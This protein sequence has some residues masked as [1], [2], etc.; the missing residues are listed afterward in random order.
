ME[1]AFDDRRKK[2][3]KNANSILGITKKLR[4]SSSLA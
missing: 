3:K 1:D 4:E 2:E